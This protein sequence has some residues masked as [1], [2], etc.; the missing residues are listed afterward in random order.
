MPH[1]ELQFLLIFGMQDGKI[2]EGLVY[3]IKL[4]NEKKNQKLTRKDTK[5]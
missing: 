3:I 5:F 4:Q 1:V 2:Y